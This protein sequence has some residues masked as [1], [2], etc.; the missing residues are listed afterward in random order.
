[1]FALKLFLAIVT[2][3]SNGTIFSAPL[4]ADTI[5]TII[6]DYECALD[7]ECEIVV[8]PTESHYSK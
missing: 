4:D 3:L 7:T 5:D 8:N 6:M 1:M 2:G